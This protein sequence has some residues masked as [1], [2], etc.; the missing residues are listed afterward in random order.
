[1]RHMIIPLA[2]GV[3][4]LAGCARHGPVETTA[5]G[6]A[7]LGAQLAN[8]EPNGATRHCVNQRDIRSKRY[9]GDGAIIFEGRGSNIYVN[10]PPRGCPELRFGDA[11]VHRTTMTQLCGG[12]IY[13]IVD[14]RTGIERGSC[15]LGEFEPYRRLRS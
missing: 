11:L 5:E 3:C 2:L 1:M 15:I 14:F 6:E 4:V 8:Y 7:Q 13:Q 10:R 9:A 12:E